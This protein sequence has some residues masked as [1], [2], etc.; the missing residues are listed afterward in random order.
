MATT[1]LYFLFYTE[2]KA[3]W[4]Y[5]TRTPPAHFIDQLLLNFA[6]AAICI[7]APQLPTFAGDSSLVKPCLIL[8]S[9][10]ALATLIIIVTSKARKQTFYNMIVASFSMLALLT[11]VLPNLG[12]PSNKPL[13]EAMQS[14]YQ[15]GDKIVNY[16]HYFYDVPLYSQQTVTLVANWDDPAMR[17]KDNWRKIFLYGLEHQPA[18]K[19]QLIKPQIL[20]KQ[21]NKKPR[22]FVFA[23]QSHL[24]FIRK[25]ASPVNIIAENETYVVLSNQ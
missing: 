11:L 12:I 24:P 22:M 5:L 15:P 14:Q 19:T 1:H 17:R 20:W 13:V 21:W 18:A 16:F 4:L 6:L 25:H 2:I 3:H 7:Y 9:S 23:R 8:G 10:I